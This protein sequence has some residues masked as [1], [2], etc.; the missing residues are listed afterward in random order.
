MRWQWCAL[1]VA[2]GALLAAD[3]P[4]DDAKKVLKDLQ[5]TWKVGEAK[6]GGVS[7]DEK[8]LEKMVV[9]IRDNRVLFKD[10]LTDS[11]AEVKLD[12]SKK[13]AWI[14]MTPAREKITIK[15]IYELD[16]DA[17]KLCWAQEGK[18]RPTTFESKEGTPTA[19][20][21]LKREKKK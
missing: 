9:V 4:S 11:D 16:G 3:K 10:G 19:L 21:V 1:I 14:D 5:G 15:G 13:P 7:P 18:E 20:F 17:L 12:P 6:I 2:T 8:L